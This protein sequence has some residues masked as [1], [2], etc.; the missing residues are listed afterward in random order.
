MR[1][2]IGEGRQADSSCSGAPCSC[3]N[4][5]G[6][7]VRRVAEH[8]AAGA[9]LF[10]K[11]LTANQVRSYVLSKRCRSL[12][13]HRQISALFQLA[14]SLIE[15]ESG[16]SP[17]PAQSNLNTQNLMRLSTTCTVPTFT[18]LKG[19]EIGNPPMTTRENKRCKNGLRDRFPKKDKSAP[20]T[21]AVHKVTQQHSENRLR[22]TRCLRLGSRGWYS[23]MKQS[24]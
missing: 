19:C 1:T 23:V 2:E 9:E 21:S 22:N 11:G 18:S 7:T 4:F 8:D 6:N 5:S 16:A 3:G 14:P 10:R 24:R 20:K 17:E 12:R 15:A 13:H